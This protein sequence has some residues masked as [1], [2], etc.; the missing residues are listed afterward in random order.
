MGAAFG[1]T[2]FGGGAGRYSIITLLTIAIGR[3]G[4]VYVAVPSIALDRQ[5]LAEDTDLVFALGNR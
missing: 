4:D 2:G 5:L 1:G 3:P